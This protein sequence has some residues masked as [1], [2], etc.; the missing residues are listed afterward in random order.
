[1]NIKKAWTRFFGSPEAKLQLD[2][3]E[4]ASV[5]RRLES[6]Y[7]DD[8]SALEARKLKLE[9]KLYGA[10]GPAPKAK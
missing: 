9:Q 5:T 6:G 4:L 10:S 7:T 3:D 2:R 1:M 8:R